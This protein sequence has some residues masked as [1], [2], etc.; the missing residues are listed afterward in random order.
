M[1]GVQGTHPLPA[2]GILGYSIQMM[3]AWRPVILSLR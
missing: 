2:G 3:P 1:K